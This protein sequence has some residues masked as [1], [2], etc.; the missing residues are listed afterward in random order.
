MYKSVRCWASRP[1]RHCMRRAVLVIPQASSESSPTS[2]EGT[3]GEV[4]IITPEDAKS[5]ME[6]DV[7]TVVQLTVSLMSL[8]VH[9][10]PRC[11][12]T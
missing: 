7:Y 1:D 12:P 11:L 3:S 10:S 2:A 6:I 9:V 8:Q 4:E 5:A